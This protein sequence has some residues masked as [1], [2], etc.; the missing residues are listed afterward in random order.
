MNRNTLIIMGIDPGLAHTGWGIIAQI[1]G[2][3]RALAYGC[4]TTA[5]Q[6]EIS[7]RLKQIYDEISTVI[8]R[9]QPTELGIEAVYFGANAKSALATGQARGAAL[10]AAAS[11]QIKVGEYSPTQVKSAIAGTGTAT[12][13]QIQYMVKVML[14]LDHIP[15]PDHAADALA[16]AICHAQLQRTSHD[17]ISQ[18]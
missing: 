11:Q 9:Y 10:V 5:A 4:I 17:R 18:R 12:K 16:I 2:R 7:L 1:G 13:E 6:D 3:R 8:L 15:A 14:T